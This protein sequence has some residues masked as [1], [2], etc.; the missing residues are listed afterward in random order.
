M[1]FIQDAPNPVYWSAYNGNTKVASIIDSC[2]DP[3]IR[4]EPNPYDEPHPVG[5]WG[6]PATIVDRVAE[7]AQAIIKG[8]YRPYEKDGEHQFFNIV[9]EE[10]FLA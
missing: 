10:D 2:R 5:M 6:Y 4:F 9:K 8:T 7:G 3:Y 1:K